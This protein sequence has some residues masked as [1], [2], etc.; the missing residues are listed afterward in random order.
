LIAFEEGKEGFE[1]DEF[2]EIAKS[3]CHDIDMSRTI[4]YLFCR[5]LSCYNLSNQKH[6]RK[7]RTIYQEYEN[8]L[9]SEQLWPFEKVKQEGVISRFRI[10]NVLGILKRIRIHHEILLYKGAVIRSFF[11]FYFPPN[12]NS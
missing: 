12:F 2:F 4:N 6:Y 8:L 7:V 9:P 1:L 5:K 11:L 3:T 10:N